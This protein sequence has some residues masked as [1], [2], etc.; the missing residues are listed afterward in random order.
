MFFAGRRATSCH[1]L[2]LARANDAETLATTLT[3]ERFDGRIHV[4]HSALDTVSAARDNEA[5]V[6]LLKVLPGADVRWAP[7]SGEYHAILNHLPAIAAVMQR[8]VRLEY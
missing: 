6:R 1:S 2:G 4:V 3:E 8:V 5:A 7:L